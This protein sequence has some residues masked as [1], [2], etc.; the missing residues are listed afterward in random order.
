MGSK[1]SFADVGDNE[2]ADADGNRP[3]RSQPKRRKHYGSGRHKAKEGTSEFAKK[4]VRNI[5]RLLR[6]N[7]DL[8]ANVHNDLE[9]E[10][11]ALRSDVADKA[12][13]KKRSA[14]IAKYHMVRF[15][16]T[17]CLCEAVLAVAAAD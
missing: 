5:E 10:L 15:F 7:K 9:R 16:G 8:P 11:A 6:R 12:L 17:S 14:M 13:H 2:D 4:R 3:P 1:R